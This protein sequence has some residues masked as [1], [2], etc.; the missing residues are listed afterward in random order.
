MLNR[1]WVSLCQ[2]GDRNLESD[3]PVLKKSSRSIFG[4]TLSRLREGKAS[5]KVSYLCQLHV[6]QK[7]GMHHGIMFCI[8]EIKRP[9]SVPQTINRN[10]SS[11]QNESIF[12][13]HSLSQGT[14]TT[15]RNRME[16]SRYSTSNENF[17]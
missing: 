4:P 11:P 5:K 6:K 3:T 14:N 2:E 9:K 10:S 7:P 1:F 17:G 12:G 13:L 15:L 8:K 16:Q